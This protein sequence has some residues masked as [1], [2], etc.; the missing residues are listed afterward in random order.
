[1]AVPIAVPIVVKDVAGLVPG[2]C[3]GKGKGNRFLND[4]CDADVLVHIIDASGKSDTGGNVLEH[5]YSR[6]G[7]QQEQ[8]A[9]GNGDGVLHDVAWIHQE[10]QR[11]ILDNLESKWETIKRKPQH[12]YDMFTGYQSQKWLVHEALRMA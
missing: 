4:L 8:P 10:L 6:S 12:L 11:W 2:A 5:N 7:W 1:M 3:E 9:Q